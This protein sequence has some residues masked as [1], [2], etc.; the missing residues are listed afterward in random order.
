MA[1]EHRREDLY[2]AGFQAA[3]LDTVLVGIERL[4][5]K[6]DELQAEQKVLSQ[7]ISRLSTELAEVKADNADHEARMRHLENSDRKWAAI[8]AT[9]SAGFTLLLKYFFP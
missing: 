3:K 4:S 2:Q 9:G 5:C 1:D 8:V 6:L 7:A